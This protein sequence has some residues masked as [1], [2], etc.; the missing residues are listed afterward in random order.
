MLVVTKHR[1]GAVG[2]PFGYQDEG[3]DPF[4]LLDAISNALSN[5]ASGSLPRPVLLAQS[6]NVRENDLVNLQ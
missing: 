5:E 2:Q 6:G 1:R 3:S 4:A